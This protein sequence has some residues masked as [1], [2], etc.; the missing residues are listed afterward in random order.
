MLYPDSEVLLYF[1]IP[2]KI[3]TAVKFFGA[4]ET[5]NL[6]AKMAGTTLPVIGGF[7]SSAHLAGLAAG[8]FIGK[9]LR[10]RY[11]GRARVSIFQ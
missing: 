7:A 1:V 3:Q 6:L 9:K 4:L 11:G 2:M 10:D 8:I 5:V